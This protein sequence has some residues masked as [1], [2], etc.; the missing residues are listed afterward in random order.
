MVYDASKRLS[1]VHSSRITKKTRIENEEKRFS[2]THRNDLFHLQGITFLSLSS[3]ESSSSC[4]FSPCRFLSFQ[5]EK[6]GHTTERLNKR[7]IVSFTGGKNKS[8]IMLSYFFT[9][10]VCAEILVFFLLFYFY[11]IQLR[12]VNFLRV[13]SSLS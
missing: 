6:F 12:L 3:C 10:L 11:C 2:V 4:P 5:V 7:H 8:K 13:V 9:W 1:K